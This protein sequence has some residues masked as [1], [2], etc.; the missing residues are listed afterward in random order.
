MQSTGVVQQLIFN[1]HISCFQCLH[2]NWCFNRQFNYS[3]T[4]A[5]IITLFRAR[6]LHLKTF[7][8]DL[9][10]LKSFEKFQMCNFSAGTSMYILFRKSWIFPRVTDIRTY[11][12]ALKIWP[13]SPHVTS[14]GKPMNCVNFTSKWFHFL[15]FLAVHTLCCLLCLLHVLFKITSP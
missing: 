1:W 13:H 2:F 14:P 3:S 10:S 6:N 5:L 15:I 7:S 11:I 4:S 12:S 8:T 9:H